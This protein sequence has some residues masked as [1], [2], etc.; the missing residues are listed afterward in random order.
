[1]SGFIINLAL[2]RQGR[3][4]IQ[5]QATARDL[6]LPEAQWPGEVRARLVIERNGEQ[7]TVRGPVEATVRQECVRCLGAFERD[8]VFDLAVFADRTGT[9]GRIEKE[10]ERDDYMKF[11]GGRELDL[12][13]EVRELLLLEQPM[14]PCCREDCRGL[15]P[16]CGADLNAGPCGCTG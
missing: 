13:D 1:M 9:S 3:S 7:V 11:H 6:D 2:V 15:C 12:R 4:E 16:G 10:L 8:D 14:M 5:T